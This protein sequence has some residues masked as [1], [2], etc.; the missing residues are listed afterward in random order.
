MAQPAALFQEERTYV[1]GVLP[2][3]KVLTLGPPTPGPAGLNHSLRQ[4]HG[5]KVILMGN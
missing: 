5:K 3:W 1:Y 2:C 4:W